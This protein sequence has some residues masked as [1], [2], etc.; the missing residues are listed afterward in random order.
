MLYFCVTQ[1]QNL[2]LNYIACNACF[3]S[4]SKGFSV[5]LSHNV[6]HNVLSVTFF[7]FGYSIT[8]T[9]IVLH[10]LISFNQIIKI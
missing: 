3:A 1:I 5:N 6:L 8:Y 10:L 4:V 7:I 2:V 9:N